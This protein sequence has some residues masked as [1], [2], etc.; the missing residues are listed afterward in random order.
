MRPTLTY[1]KERF[2]YY[3]QLCFDGSLERPIIKLSLRSTGLGVTQQRIERDANG[4]ET[5]RDA[6]IEI[7]VRHDLPEVEYIDT[8]VHEMIHYYIFMNKLQDNAAH[9]K[10]FMAKAQEITRKYGIKVT[11]NYELT[12]EEQVNARGRNRW[13][14]VAHDDAGNTLMAVVARGK[15]FELWD[16][17]E[18]APDLHDVRWWLSNREIFGTFP[19]VVSPQ[20]YSVDPSQI[21]SYLIDAQ[22]L[23]KD[24]DVIRPVD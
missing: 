1:F 9:G 10:L 16:A 11:V 3:N 5:G 23:I 6:L 20:L 15:V 22:P 13:V 4:N 12:D 8:L 21:E 7:S 18:Q 24:G 14:C 19:L 2:D 17:F